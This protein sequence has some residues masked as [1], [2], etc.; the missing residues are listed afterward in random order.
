MTPDTALTA[1][2]ITLAALITLAIAAGVLILLIQARRAVKAAERSARYPLR[3]P[4]SHGAALA[5]SAAHI[6]P[7]V[8][9]RALTGRSSGD[10]I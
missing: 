3:A 10:G 1:T 7:T 6:R 8:P 5:T 4:E 9:L 2:M